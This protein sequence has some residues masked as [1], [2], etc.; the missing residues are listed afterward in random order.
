MSELKEWQNI[1]NLVE[2]FKEEGLTVE[3]YLKAAWCKKPQLFYQSPETIAQHIHFVQELE[4]SR[5]RKS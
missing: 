3:E 4:K 1:R 5:L 2:K